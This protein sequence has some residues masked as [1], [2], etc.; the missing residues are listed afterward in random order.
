M[1]PYTTYEAGIV[2]ATK[3]PNSGRDDR[4]TVT[5]HK[6][7]VNDDW[8]IETVSKTRHIFT[9]DL[10]DYLEFMEDS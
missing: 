6:S 3:E 1:R 7:M 4:I 10:F 5:R 9:S 2:P 8:T